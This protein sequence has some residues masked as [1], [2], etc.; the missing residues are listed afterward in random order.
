MCAQK[1]LLELI[2][3]ICSSC[4][5]LSSVEEGY[6]EGIVCNLC[7]K[8]KSIEEHREN[9]VKNLGRSVEKNGKYSI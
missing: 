1:N 4:N 5:S 8:L 2:P 6:G 9:A 7:Q 3:A